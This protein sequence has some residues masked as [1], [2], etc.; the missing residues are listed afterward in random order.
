MEELLREQD[1]RFARPDGEIQDGTLPNKLK[2]R[3]IFCAKA[4]KLRNS[5]GVGS[6]TKKIK[7]MDLAFRRSWGLEA[8]K[9]WNHVVKLDL[10]VTENEKLTFIVVNLQKA[11]AAI[12]H[13]VVALLLADEKTSETRDDFG[14]IARYV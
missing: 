5:A 14:A 13:A 9:L 6:L 10:T 8:M 7:M 3:Y 11:D 1:I 12:K 2:F 4:K